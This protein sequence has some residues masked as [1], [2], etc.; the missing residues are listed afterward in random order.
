MRPE[1][2]ARGTER[3]GNCDS[4]RRLLMTT[5]RST[6]ASGRTTRM[7]QIGVGQWGKNLA[8]NFA[9]LAD[10]VWLCDVDAGQHA[11]LAQRHSTARMTADADDVLADDSVEAVV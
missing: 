4:F 6:S 8:R 9:D 10:L 5:E 11:E 3:S 2:T 1:G 7:A